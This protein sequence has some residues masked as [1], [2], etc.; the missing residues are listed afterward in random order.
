MN[1]RISRSLEARLVLTVGLALLLFSAVAGIFVYLSA[2][3]QQLAL[4]D[5]LQQQLVGTVQVQAEVAAFAANSQIA[6]GVLEGLLVNPVIL[7]ARIESGTGFKAELGSRKN[8][9]FEHGKTYTLFSPVD[10]LE[11]IG[12]LVVVQNDD[13]VNRTAAAAAVLQ[14]GLMLAEVLVAAII[15]AVVLRIMLIKPITRLAQAMA[16]IQPGSASRLAV[17]A[18]NATNELGALANSANTLLAAAEAA[19]AEVEVQRDELERLA[20]HDHLTGLPM[21]RLADDRL[22]VACRSAHRNH[23]KVALLFIDL[24]DFKAVNDDHGHAVG[25]AVLQAVAGR[26]RECIRGEDTAARIGGDEFLVILGGLA[27]ARAAAVV[28]ENIGSALA[29]PFAVADLELQLGASIGIAV[30]PDHTGDVDAMRRVADQ[31]MYQVKKSGKGAA[32]FID[33]ASPASPA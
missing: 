1:S 3:R 19:I 13:Q 23:T 16:T 12:A 2:Y 31:A 8:A 26:L 5:S 20:T 6:Q 25:D 7:A 15:M 11:P 29:R 30:F 22:H 18:S 28:A 27:D 4:A 24:D 33:Q 14:T 9:N 17:D 32:A 21:A 10:H